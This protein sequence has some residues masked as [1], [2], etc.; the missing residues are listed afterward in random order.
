MT[1]LP[2]TAAVLEPS[3][4]AA[5]DDPAPEVTLSIPEPAP[6]TF[7]I[8][9]DELLLARARRGD[10]AAIER[11]Y[12]TFERPVYNLARRL[13]RTAHDAEDVLQETFLEVFR[14]L[15]R[16]RG[17][18]SFAGWVRKVAASKALQRLRKERGG[19]SETGLD[20]ELAECLPAPGEGLLEPVLARVDL[21]TALASL[22]DTARAVLWLHEV[23]GWNHD[24]IASLWGK[25][26]SF[27]KSQLSRACAR[28]RT[29]LGTEGRPS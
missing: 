13:C 15:P 12:R 1:P 3:G 24:E 25:S 8:E 21:E 7:S 23:E 5:A 22:G 18:G 9:V 6:G 16:F 27:S 10:Q 28:L 2:A 20:D 29:L 26:A 14:S 11:L 4:A 17:E 19:R